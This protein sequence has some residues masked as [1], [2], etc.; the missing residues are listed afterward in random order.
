MNGKGIFCFLL[1][2]AFFTLE[3]GFLDR[4]TEERRSIAQAKALAFEAEKA[5]LVRS[6]M[7]N[8]VD[9]A[10]DKGLLQGLQLN[11]GPQEIK[12]HVN[13]RLAALFRKMEKAYNDEISISFDTK[14]LQESFL[15]KN[16]SVIVTRLDKKTIEAEYCFTGG[17]MASNTVSAKITGKGVTQIFRMPAGYTVKAEVLA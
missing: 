11:L 8:S 14:S 17:I 16:S 2:L 1:L 4:A 10:I 15:N 6:L 13:S 12:G 5:F 7:E 9:L 3:I